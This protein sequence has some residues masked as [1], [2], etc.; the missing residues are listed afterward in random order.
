MAEYTA[1]KYRVFLSYS[2]RDAAWGRWLRAALEGYRI[3]EDLVGRPTPAGPVPTTLRPIFG[4]RESFSVGASLAEQTSTALRASQFLIVLCSPHAAKSRHVN[5]EIR[6]FRSMGRADRVIPVIVDGKPGD[7]ARQ[8]GRS[9]A[10]MFSAGV[11]L[12]ARAA[13][14]TDRRAVGAGCCRHP[15]RRRRQGPRPAKGGGATSRARHRRHR[16]SR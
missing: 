13:S 10:R 7:P 3:D 8:A 5:E 1:L 2:H 12:Q 11:T 4:G 6:R 15:A 14:P 9:R 16:T